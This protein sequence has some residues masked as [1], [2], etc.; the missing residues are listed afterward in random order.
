MCRTTTDDEPRFSDFMESLSSELVLAPD[1][2]EKSLG[3]SDLN[4]NHTRIFT[5]KNRD[6]L[7]QRNPKII[8][9]PLVSH[10]IERDRQ[11][12]A[13]TW[14]LGVSVALHSTSPSP[15]LPSWGNSKSG[16]FIISTVVER[17]RG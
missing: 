15:P 1:K 10:I 2:E 9:L 6:T 17:D 16:N 7:L 5:G 3:S 4:F 8:P 13:S 14:R 12:D 11:P